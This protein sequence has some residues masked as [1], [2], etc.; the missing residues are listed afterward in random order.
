MLSIKVLFPIS[1]IIHVYVYL[2]LEI[3]FSH[4]VPYFLNLHTNTKVGALLTDHT[5]SFLKCVMTL[6]GL[7]KYLLA[8]PCH[9]LYF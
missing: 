5:L 3:I 7:R 9:C 6:T 1:A 2:I 8:V 4:D